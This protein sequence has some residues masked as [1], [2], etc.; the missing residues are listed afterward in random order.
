MCV[1]V[2][3][4]V[5]VRKE[6]MPRKVTVAIVQAAPYPFDLDRSLEK[7]LKK[8]K[9]AAAQG[10]HLVVFGETWL[11]GYP[12]WIDH[13]RDVAVWNHA[14]TREVFAEL[15]H[16]SVSVDGPEVESLSGLAADLGIVLAIGVNEKLD[17]GAGNGTLYNSVLI[18]DADG[19]LVLHHRKLVPTHGERLLWGR[20]D[21][22]GLGGVETAVGR[23]G[24]LI[25]WEHWMPLARQAMHVSGEQIHLALW[26]E[27]HDLHQLASRHFA[28]EGRC[29]VLA[30][31]QLLTAAGLPSQL[32][33]VNDLEPESLLL[34]GGSAVIGPD[35]DYVVEPAAAEEEIVLAELDLEAIDREVMTLDVTGH[36]HRPDV[37][38]FEVKKREG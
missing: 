38:A 35:G 16:S 36:Y 21:G 14:P 27:V 19:A 9:E 33:T 23:V 13:C 29:F 17:A 1:C 26:P 8:T 22:R 32:A 20:G 31:G 5:G 28:F 30:A 6:K 10:A 15:R 12:T 3:T 24:T 18:F 7:A 11:S 34:R 4:I 25:C 2:E 37:F